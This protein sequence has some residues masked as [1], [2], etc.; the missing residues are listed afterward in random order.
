[1]ASLDNGWLSR[2]RPH[3]API[4]LTVLLLS[5]LATYLSLRQDNEWERVF[6]PAAAR[7]WTGDD[8]YSADGRYQY[9]PF[10]AWLTLPWVGLS[11]AAS[12]IAFVAVSLACTVAVLWC[13]WRL[14]GGRTWS[15][16]AARWAV[17]AGSCCGL[18]YLFNCLVHQQTDV[19]IAALLIGGCLALHV[20][21]PIAAATGFGLATAMKCTPLLFAPYLVWRG[22]PLAAAW[23]MVVALGVNFLPDLVSHPPEG[24]TW[25][26]AFAGRLL[27][28]LGRAD[29]VPGSWGQW[30]E[31][32]YNQSLAGAAQR[33][34]LTVPQWDADRVRVVDN[35]SSVAPGT[36]RVTLLAVEVLLLLLAV[37]LV[38]RPF[39]ASADPDRETLEYGIVLCLMLLLSPMSSAAHFCTLLLPGMCLARRLAV[40]RDRI[41]LVLLA[42]A[43]T[44]A[45]LSN[46]DL[47]GQKLYTTALWGGCVM[48]NTLFLLAASLRELSR[49]PALEPRLALSVDRFTLPAGA[50]YRRPVTPPLS[51]SSAAGKGASSASS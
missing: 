8:L 35:G 22:R 44:A 11:H 31:V 2:V 36:I 33:W 45:V 24:G 15:R 23:L 25:L 30:S 4:G 18:F 34:S 7:L 17:W 12:R 27:S 42:A 51:A 9:P 1:M 47:I 20:G 3:A 28:P 13:A 43:L 38:G 5:T 37:S 6:V 26:G 21:R 50:F 14:T 16:P 39:R 41:L 48:F 29:H 40:S 10:T 19:V 46:K 32:L 49:S